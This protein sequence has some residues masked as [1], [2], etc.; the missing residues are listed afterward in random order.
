MSYNMK[1]ENFLDLQTYK[2]LKPDDSSIIVLSGVLSNKLQCV[3]PFSWCCVISK[4][5]GY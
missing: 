4:S 5:S 2:K 1:S 3:I